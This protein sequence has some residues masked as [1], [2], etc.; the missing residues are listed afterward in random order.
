MAN[1]VHEVTVV[2]A[3]TGTGMIVSWKSALGSV[4]YYS[5]YRGLSNDGAY[6]KIATNISVNFYLDNTAYQNERTDYW[7]YVT[8]TDN[9]GESEPSKGVTDEATSRRSMS[10][11]LQP[12]FEGTGSG[13]SIPRILSYQTKRNEIILRRDGALC[14]LW[15]LKTA[16]PVCTACWD[17]ARMQPSYDDC[18]TCFGTGLLGGYELFPGLL[19]KFEPY[20]NTQILSDSGKKLTSPPRSWC[21]PY[22]PI[23][24]GDVLVR[25]SNNVRYEAQNIGPKI[26]HEIAF[27]QEFD[28]IQIQRRENPGVFLLGVS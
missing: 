7:Y 18:P 10:D 15:V 3:L 13:L 11:Q 16:G 20:V 19:F 27:R 21:S 17:P 26:V 8:A 4:L 28:L 1:K 6:T 9:L 22:P 24:P 14:D 23:Q 5:V 25:R 12:I 2:N